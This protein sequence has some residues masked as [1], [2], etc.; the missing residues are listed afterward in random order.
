MK[1]NAFIVQLKHKDLNFTG[2]LSYRD[3]S[4]PCNFKKIGKDLFL[5]NFKI[6]LDFSFQEAVSFKDKSKEMVV[7][8]IAFGRKLFPDRQPERSRRPSDHFR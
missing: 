6:Q 4:L 3:N 5:A 7:M 8:R 2:I 1:Y